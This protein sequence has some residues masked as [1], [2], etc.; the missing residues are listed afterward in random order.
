MRPLNRLGSIK[1]KLGVVII[2][3]VVVSVAVVVYGWRTGVR[4]R[5]LLIVTSLVA[6][7]VI[8]FLAHGMTRPLRE[9]AAATQRVS[10]G[11]FDVKVSTTSRDEVGDLARAFNS[12]AA[13]IA[14]LDR[15]RS[16][17]V[18]NV[19][20][21]LRTPLAAVRARL[22]NVVDGI[23]PAD[24][25]AMEAMLRSI[26]RLCRLVEQLLELSRF[27]SGAPLG[28][29]T[30]A[31]ADVIDAVVSEVQL[32]GDGTAID[33]VLRGE[34][35]VLG[36][37]ERIHQV[38][39]NLLDNAVQHSPKGVT[40]TIEAMTTPTGTTVIV[41]DRGPGIPTDSVHRVFDRFYRVPQVGSAS[42]SGL[43]LAI[44]RSIVDLHGATIRAESAAPSGCRMVVQFPGTTA[45]P[46]A[47]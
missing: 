14:V 1:V 46:I 39:A 31:V 5:F 40:V 29:Q 20:H 8:Q 34:P 22:E 30:F 25:A 24:G 36:D 4:P 44:V 7:A 42:G 6:L 12:M 37:P 35:L 11:D 10:R 33:V 3:S 13:R 43:G 17:F 45:K 16:A 41:S 9:M 26:E 27:E 21:E 15:E 38:I 18:A 23:E 28:R 32:A 47:S 19:S 2:A